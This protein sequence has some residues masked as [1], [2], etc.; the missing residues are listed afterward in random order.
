VKL[1]AKLNSNYFEN[2]S[3]WF[4]DET[5]RIESCLCDVSNLVMSNTPYAP[6]EV[7][8]YRAHLC[9]LSMSLCVCVTQER[10]IISDAER[11]ER[12]VAY[13][14]STDG[15]ASWTQTDAPADLSVARLLC[16]LP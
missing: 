6:D 12:T 15:G 7:Y 1:I 10:H 4:V 2:V 5:R 14:A 8:S 9:Q 11:A 13:Y 3:L 16:E